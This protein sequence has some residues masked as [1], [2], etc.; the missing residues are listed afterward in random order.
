MILRLYSLDGN[1]KIVST[2][3]ISTEMEA[4]TIVEKHIAGSGYWNLKVV[5]DEDYS[6]RFTATTPAG[7]AGRNVAALDF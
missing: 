5:D 2:V 6:L 1:F 7:R 4:R 3:E